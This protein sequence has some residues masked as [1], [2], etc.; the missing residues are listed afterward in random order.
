MVSE[1]TQK[2]LFLISEGY[3][4]S[5]ITQILGYKNTNTIYHIASTYKVKIR[6]AHANKHDEMRKYKAEGHTTSE[7]AEKYGV[8]KGTAQQICKGIAIQKA[9]GDHKYKGRYF[10]V[11]KKY[12]SI[13]HVIPLSKGGTHSWDNV[14]LAHFSCNSAKG[15]SLV[16]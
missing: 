8:C 2:A 15:A 13:D 14:K 7:V 11:G 3:T 9:R 16:G 10:I 5:E 4:A 1:R 12:P 6:K